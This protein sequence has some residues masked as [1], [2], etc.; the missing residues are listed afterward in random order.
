MLIKIVRQYNGSSLKSDNLDVASV[1]EHNL[2][3][4]YA[5]NTSLHLISSPRPLPFSDN[6]PRNNVKLLPRPLYLLFHAPVRFSSGG[7]IFHVC[8]HISFFANVLYCR[9]QVV[10]MAFANNTSKLYIQS[11]RR[12]NVYL[13]VTKQDCMEV[14]TTVLMILCCHYMLIEINSGPDSKLVSRLRC[15]YSIS[16]SKTYVPP[17]T[18]NNL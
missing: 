3:L 13:L 4:P 15:F 14:L 5:S 6:F 1:V 2:A 9:C 10:H 16:L 11:W 18:T 12:I 7:E 8:Y 17:S